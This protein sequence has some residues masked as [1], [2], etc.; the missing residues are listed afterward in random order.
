MNS[1]NCKNKLELDHAWRYFELHAN[2][3]ISL[4]RYYVVIFSLYITGIGFMLI[5]FD[6]LVRSSGK[7]SSVE[8]IFVIIFS[9]IF[10]IITLIF[11]HLDQR[12]RDLIHL[13]E[14]AL[15][16]LEN[17]F[18][19][20]DEIKIFNREKVSS[21]NCSCYKHTKC[22]N[23]FF[24]LSIISAVFIIGFSFCHALNETNQINKPV[25]ANQTIDKAP[26]KS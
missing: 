1:D 3:R 11:F 9:A 22:F 16:Q 23:S 21:D 15:V 2:Q 26:S 13:S 5:R 25:T 4:F 8:E 24:L 12:N 10:M 20:T 19:F 7:A 17:N 18:N 6:H 14:D